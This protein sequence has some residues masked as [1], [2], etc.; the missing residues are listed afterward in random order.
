MLD[1]RG[2][3]AGYGSS[4]VLFDVNLTIQEGEIVALLGR[5]GMGKTTTVRSIMGLVSPTEGSLS[6]KSENLRALQTDA[7]ARLGIG[8][9]PEGRHVFASLSVF[10]NLVATSA[11]REAGSA[12][13]TLERV[14]DLFP[15][16]RERANQLAGTL[17]GGE[18]QM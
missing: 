16:L 11:N 6:F 8:L 18:Q 12:F 15:G 3:T 2:L 1:I 14:F 13:W 17:S 10:E 4:K 5:N 7:I 9:V